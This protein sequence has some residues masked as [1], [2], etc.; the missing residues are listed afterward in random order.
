MPLFTAASSW[1]VAQRWSSG[2]REIG[3]V[4]LVKNL[5]RV[6][7][8]KGMFLSPQHFQ[9]QDDFFEDALQ[10]RCSTSSNCNWGLT[11]IAVDHES[12][13]NGLFRLR[14]CRGVFSE[15]L[16]VH[17]PDSDP[18]PESREIAP[19]F[20]PTAPHADVFLALPEK[21]VRGRNISIAQ[22]DAPTRYIAQL[23]NLTDQIS[24]TD[25]KPVQVCAKNLR[26]AFGS[27]ALDGLSLIRISRVVRNASGAYM[28]D[29]QFVPPSLSL[30]AS[31]YVLILLRR[32]V[33][34]LAAKAA[35]LSAQRRQKGRSQA[36]FQSGDIGAFWLLHTINTYLPKLKH[37]W[38]QR[39]RHPEDLYITML[40]LAGS[41]TTFAL[42]GESGNLPD[43]DHN[44]LGRCFTELNGKIHELL[45]TAIPT[46]CVA[47]PLQLQEKST[48]AGNI[49]DGEL[50][51]Q[52]NFVLSVNAKMGVDDLIRQVPRLIKVSPPAELP[53]LIRNALPGITLRHLP[54]P[55]DGIPMKLDRQYFA[56]DQT[57]L[58]W[59]GLAR[60]REVRVF[61]PEEIANPDFE[62][63]VV[64]N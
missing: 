36:A 51:R 62:L 41:L 2:L 18:A 13:S 58:L 34:T 49:K 57:G 44:E 10:F 5:Q 47:V 21:R 6:V 20:P 56:L 8:A 52:T 59:D 7:W 9:A 54:V 35:S 17:L 38:T 40:T 22:S 48:W 50:F 1:Q 45:E 39:R 30:E 32:L 27:E 19:Y 64:K 53:R 28:V 55:P 42:T 26:I 3:G 4:F 33:E 60:D 25:E 61:V 31:E 46:R 16:S 23:C 14:N 12:L 43:Y 37:L 29:P 15:G 11:D 63:L 24:G